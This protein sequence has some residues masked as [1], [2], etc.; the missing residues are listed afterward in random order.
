METIVAIQIVK[1]L[2]Q[3]WLILEAQFSMKFYGTRQVGYV[4]KMGRQIRWIY[5]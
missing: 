1:V 3:N 5:S 4:R 2:S